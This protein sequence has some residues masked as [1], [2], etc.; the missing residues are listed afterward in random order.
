MTDTGLELGPKALG[1]SVK[2]FVVE[3]DAYYTSAF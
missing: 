1:S 3:N 2:E